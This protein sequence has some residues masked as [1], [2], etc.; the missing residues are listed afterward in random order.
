[1]LTVVLCS[2]FLLRAFG[3][4]EKHT[5]GIGLKLL[6]KV[7]ALLWLWLSSVSNPVYVLM[8]LP[9]VH[10]AHMLLVVSCNNRTWGFVAAFSLI[11]INC[12]H[13]KIGLDCANKFFIVSFVGL[14]T[15]LSHSDLLCYTRTTDMPLNWSRLPWPVATYA[16]SL[17]T[18]F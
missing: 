4:W 11:W 2:V 3:S 8:I 17:L 5:K 18:F 9:S 15:F 10:I 14:S 6:Q 1:M 13:E 12:W 16:S 7:D